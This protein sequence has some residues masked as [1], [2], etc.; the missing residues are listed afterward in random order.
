MPL[1]YMKMM[2]MCSSEMPVRLHSV[3]AESTPVVIFTAL[4]TLCLIGNVISKEC[5]NVV[6]L[7]HPFYC[8]DIL[9]SCY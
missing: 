1:S 9:I 2:T 6:L 3:P 4:R 8:Y 5:F 7:K